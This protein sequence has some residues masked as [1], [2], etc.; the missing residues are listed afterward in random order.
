[1][2]IYIGTLL[3]MFLFF[4]CK[5]KPESYTELL[6]TLSEVKIVDDNEFDFGEINHGDTLTHTFILKNVSQNVYK[7]ENVQV[8]CGCTT[9]IFTRDSVKTQDYAKIKIEYIP[10][11]E[12]SGLV[13]KSIV[14]SDN[15][16][17]G[18]NTMSL[19]GIV[20]KN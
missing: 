19:K 1:M 3:F 2:N 7:I 9:V 15:S 4:S 6:S 5:K 10:S 8:S 17:S 13:K 16:K 18:F 12:D 14:V 11:Q 20:L